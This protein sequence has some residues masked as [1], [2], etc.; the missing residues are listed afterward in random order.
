MNPGLAL[1]NNWWFERSLRGRAG[2]RGSK[3]EK[4]KKK[5]I[6]WGAI[7]TQNGIKRPEGYNL[8][9]QGKKLGLE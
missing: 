4:K 7:E 6:A 1:G 3:L 9:F 8:V 5:L 2:N